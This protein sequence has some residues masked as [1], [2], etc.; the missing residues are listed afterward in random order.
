MRETASQPA[1]VSKAVLDHGL[2]ICET[3]G[4]VLIMYWGRQSNYQVAGKG[5]ER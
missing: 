3:Y 1:E 5:S 4:L 2:D